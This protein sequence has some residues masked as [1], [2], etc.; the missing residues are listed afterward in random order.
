MM[1]HAYLIMAHANFQQLAFLISLLDDP[2]N[3][4]F[5]HIDA[6]ANFTEEDKHMLEDA[7]KQSNLLLTDRKA[8]YW[9]GFSQ[10]KAEFLLFERAKLYG[11]YHFYHLLSGSDLPIV[12]QDRIHQFFDEHS[13][14]I[15]L[16]RMTLE[17]D[18]ENINR[19][20]YYHFFEAFTPRTIPGV[21]GKGLFKLYRFLEV[22]IQ[23]IMG[24]NL[25]KK[26]HLK[27]MKASQWASLPEDVVLSLLE[28]KEWVFKTFGKTFIPDEVFLPLFLNKFGFDND[29]FDN[30]IKQNIPDEYQ[31]NLRFVNWWDGN[32]YVWTNSKEDKRQLQRL[33]DKGYFFTRKF[34]LSE[35]DE[36]F[37][38][39]LRLTKKRN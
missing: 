37:D 9:G 38:F 2:R 27:P 34:D 33:A 19:L 7:S 5:V 31:A 22:S 18:P 8:I 39:I 6:K 11:R 36:L 23:K 28:H 21:F 14:S 10:V 17:G 35:E 30:T 32:P 12:H 25:L 29:V 24:V 13:Q 16:N 3:D 15:F 20:K 26:Y 4:I 1:K